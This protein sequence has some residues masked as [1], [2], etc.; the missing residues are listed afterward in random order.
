[1]TLET[2]SPGYCPY[3]LKP[4]FVMIDSFYQFWV[5]LIAFLHAL[6]NTEA[7][8]DITA[9]KKK[10]MAFESSIESSRLIKFTAVNFYSHA[11]H[12]ILHA[13]QKK[14]KHTHKKKMKTNRKILLSRM[15]HRRKAWTRKKKPH[16]KIIFH[17]LVLFLFS[18]VFCES[19]I[20]N[21]RRARSINA[22]ALI[23][24]LSFNLFL[25]YCF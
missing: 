12:S 2:S 21:Q 6:E 13:H 8:S 3:K 25:Y 24:I 23:T 1:M 4:A 18:C 5:L 17:S 22:C 11:T 16:C 19:K 9:W 15:E 10:F 14:K 20:E 7:G